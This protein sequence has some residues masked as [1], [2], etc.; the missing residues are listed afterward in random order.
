MTTSALPLPPSMRIFPVTIQ[1]DSRGV[2]KRAITAGFDRAR[3]IASE[4]TSD[5]LMSFTTTAKT[6]PTNT[7][8]MRMKTRQPVG[9]NFFQFRDHQS[10]R[11]RGG[12]DDG[13]TV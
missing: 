4:K 2:P 7:A 1:P 9:T 8:T 3:A 11:G 6:P 10:P 5:D 13:V 12:T